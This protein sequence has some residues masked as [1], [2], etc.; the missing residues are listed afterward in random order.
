MDETRDVEL[1]REL[2]VLSEPEHSSE[3]W[4]DVRLQVREAVEARRRSPLRR[5]H[6]AF[7]PR[8]LRFALAVLALATAAVAVLLTGLPETQGPESVS[9]AEV[10]RRAMSACSSGHTWRADLL[11][12][13]YGS[14]MWELTPR[15]DTILIRFV[16]V[17]D[18]SY[19]FTFHA[20]RSPHSRVT[21]V[22][23]YDARTGVIAGREAGRPWE[24][25]THY[26][27]GPPDAPAAAL[28]GVD[29][30][31]T[32][33]AVA[34]STR[35]NLNEAVVD[36]RPAWTVTCTKGDMAGLP[37]TDADWPVYTISVDKETWL[38]LRY[39][40]VQAGTLIL[41]VRYRHV[42][43]DEPFSSG[44]FTA[45]P[46]PGDAVRRSDRGF[47]PISLVAAGAG[48]DVRPVVPRV[49]QG[50]ELSG[51]WVARRSASANGLVT[52]R[53]VFVLQFRSGFDSLTVSTRRI[54]DPYF[55]PDN[56]PF[57][58]RANPDWSRMASTEARL[59]SG[60]FAGAVAR[61]VVA[62]DI[63][64]P[65]LWA[66]KDGVLLTVAGGATAKELLAVAES[67]QAVPLPSASPA[68]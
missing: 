62:T 68:D 9:A 44:A 32:L 30:G 39:K 46:S 36:G 3:Y 21:S 58:D 67:L 19:R 45:R 16:G 66:V 12:R 56:D 18:G 53:H 8:K 27:P 51:V 17:S 25:T 22:E 50:Y 31:A 15:Y 48:G 4:R 33:R 24:I 55:T 63:S 42:R 35:M 49:P 34:A 64:A 5:L 57:E 60:V 52:A 59:R 11:V 47:K 26:P 2:E 38:P 40:V 7:A 10:L 6:A 43:I 13:M 37:R 61:I 29:L 20:G 28:S 54:D 65:H 14:E 23:M 41:D 1:G